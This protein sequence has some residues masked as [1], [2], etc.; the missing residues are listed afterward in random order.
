MKLNEIDNKEKNKKNKM[1]F[2]RHGDGGEIIISSR[3]RLARNMSDIPFPQWATDQ[4]LAK[5]GEQVQEAIS[6]SSFL[7][8]LSFISMDKLSSLDKLSLSEEH[9]ISPQFAETSKGAFLAISDSHNISIMVNEE[10]HVRIQVL[11]AGNGV[12]NSW[13]L[14]NKVDDELGKN[15]KFAFSE[16]WGYLTACPTNVGTALRVSLMLHLPALVMTQQM[17]SLLQMVNQVGGVV[18]GLFGEGTHS[19]GNFYQISNGSTLGRREEEVVE[20]IKNIGLQIADK[21]KSAR[22]VLLSQAKDK[23]SDHSHR[24][25]GIL[26]NAKL[27]SF[28][29]AMEL[30]SMLRLGMDLKLI[31]SININELNKLIIEMRSAH[32]SSIKGLHLNPKEEEQARTVLIQSILK[33]RRKISV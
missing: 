20:H 19:V 13:T 32:L 8:E 23:L 33:K 26:K 9:V 14:A 3:I 7:S 2:A 17:P 21:E 11:S 27:M 22:K 4:Q 18:R 6:A 30:L 5:I 25:L 24:A 29:E 15:I 16:K 10:D 31:D 28:E 12:D 1:W